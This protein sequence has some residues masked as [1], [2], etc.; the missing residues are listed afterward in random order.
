MRF[1]KLT[2]LAC[3][4]FLLLFAEK[5]FSFQQEGEYLYGADVSFVPEL[6]SLGIQTY[7]IENNEKDILHILKES[8]FNTIRVRVW[9]TPETVHSS[10]EEVLTFSE[11]IKE[12]GMKVF[13]NIHYSDTWADPGKQT[14]PKAWQGLEFEQLSDSVYNYTARLVSAIQPEIIQIGNE[15]NGG[16]LWPEGKYDKPSQLEALLSSGIE[17]VRD[18][19]PE[20]DIVLHYAGYE[21]ATEFFL[22][23]NTLDFDI[24]ALSYYPFWHGK[25]LTDLEEVFKDISDTF[26]KRI[27]VAEIAYP[28]DELDY[29]AEYLVDQFP[30]SE[31]GQLDFIHHV[32]SLLKETNWGYGT[33]LWGGVTDAYKTPKPETEGYFW[34]NQ[35][36]LDYNN[37]AL[38][39]LQLP[40]VTA[41]HTEQEFL[42]PTGFTLQAYPNPFNP[43]TN[44]L[45]EIEQPANLSIEVYDLVGRR[46]ASLFS[47]WVNSGNHSFSLEM[48]FQAS[49]TYF[50]KA[51]TNSETKFL[52]IQLIK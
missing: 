15:L 51:E 14:I 25:S 43:A 26:S 16:L 6:R 46:V 23:L 11:E 35:A 40:N 7:D 30:P 50:I 9:H 44:V 37:K 10:F 27:I 29:T 3:L 36:L 13:L 33:I 21:Y 28:F 22:N 47:G 41:V 32:D 4:S 52:K 24:I 42:N 34:E 8:G 12:L 39:I 49:G 45:V 19:A 18:H 38:P 31:K 2:L 48:P 20:T 1:Q 17:A 5:G